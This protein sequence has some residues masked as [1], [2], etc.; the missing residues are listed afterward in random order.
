MVSEEKRAEILEKL[1]NGVL[2]FDEDLVSE[3]S[4]EA[5]EEGMDP[6]E[7]I[8]DGLAAGMDVVGELFSKKEYFVPEVLMSAD[9]L[10]VG[11]DILRPHVDMDQKSK[12][13]GE[14][15]I[16]TVEGDVHDIG[17]N[18]VKMMFE[19]AGFTVHDLGKDVPVDRFVEEQIRTDSDI[20]CLSAMM[21]TT[22]LGMQTVIEKLRAKN[23][24][25][26][27]MIGG[28][29]VSMEIA[30]RWGAD[31]YAPDAHNALQEALNMIKGLREMQAEE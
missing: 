10:Y 31:G 25:V 17:K 19:I 29:P 28:A 18:L 5:L 6:Y 8:M 4:H 27:I 22:M 21:T 16:G 11:L 3:A 14:V 13:V 24:N 15:V 20:V 9:A 23:P 1:K 7:A 2:E 12:A 30:E 26:K